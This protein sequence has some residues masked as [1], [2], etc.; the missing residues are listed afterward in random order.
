[1][2]NKH[3]KI[4]FLILLSSMKLSAN[5]DSLTH[6]FFTS[7]SKE[8]R[9]DAAIQLGRH[10]RGVELDSLK[11]YGLRLE[12][13]GKP[14]HR[15]ALVQG[16]LFQGIYHYQKSE[17]DSAI[18]QFRNQLRIAQ[19][20]NDSAQIA[21]ALNNLGATY[22]N[23]GSSQTGIKY[24]RD[25]FRI[26]QE[27]GFEDDAMETL[28][29]ICVAMI[30]N[31]AAYSEK[32]IDKYLRM[33]EEH[34]VNKTDKKV[35]LIYMYGAWSLSYSLRKI[36]PDSA[37]AYANKALAEISP[38]DQHA[39]IYVLPSKAMAYHQK[40]NFKEAEKTF[41]EALS[42]NLKYGGVVDEVAIT[43]LLIDLYLDLNRLDDAKKML[44]KTDKLLE[45]LDD[46]RRTADNYDL[47]SKWYKK[48]QQWQNAYNAL[49]L[50]TQLKDSLNKKENAIEIVSMR[51]LIE[52]ERLEF[53]NNLLTAERDLEKQ[54]AEKEKARRNVFLALALSILAIAGLLWYQYQRTNRYNQQL[55]DLNQ[56][57]SISEQQL[58]QLNSAK[59]KYF[60]ILSHDL[61]NPLMAFESLS[62]KLLQD[63]P[64]QQRE[65]AA[66][67][68][69]Q[70]TA[71]RNLLNN[72]LI[73]SKS[74]QGLI[75]STPSALLWHEL[76]SEAL[77]IYSTEA[78]QK[79][80]L[81]KLDVSQDCLAFADKQAM[82]TVLRNLAGNAMKFTERGEISIIA[83][84]ENGMI[85]TSICDTG[86]GISEE[87][88]GSI[89]E[90]SGKQQSGLGLVLCKE[91]VEVNGGHMSIESHV[92][93]GTKVN[94]RVPA[95]R[96]SG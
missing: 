22:S 81:L 1:M 61:R 46:I 39:L 77:E 60:S 20:D 32:E 83:K 87:K 85:H 73:W 67:M 21:H 69:R 14:A 65:T 36:E 49:E 30:E 52:E 54:K 70:S 18:I 8:T 72:I 48:K 13:L 55:E 53:D 89:F 47:W 41:L 79:G 31:T 86:I 24:Y 59:D 5:V 76:C 23:Q 91:L 58:Q 71:L 75:S 40:G 84:E 16:H 42:A 38:E 17:F 43:Q 56:Q 12:Q 90:L 64:E 2:K 34:W 19:Q 45:S 82:Q 94:V 15:K 80:V 29:N 10:Y 92:G 51:N 66:L 88:L 4:M 9:I 50:S 7:K 3:V 62:E 57:L 74:Q 6:L 37:L 68:Y 28:Y 44:E 78:E 35:L 95:F 26:K 96:Y 33:V 63:K 27:A 11:A 25:A 93:L